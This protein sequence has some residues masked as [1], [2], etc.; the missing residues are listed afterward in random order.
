MIR[1]IA[2]IFFHPKNL[3]EENSGKRKNIVMVIAFLDILLAGTALAIKTGNI[4]MSFPMI[5]LGFFAS[6]ALEICV[7]YIIALVNGI[8]IR[9][10]DAWRIFFPFFTASEFILGI[11]RLISEGLNLQNYA[12][13]EVVFTVIDCLVAV[14]LGYIL[15]LY[16]KT[17]KKAQRVAM[18]SF[19]IY[20]AFTLIKLFT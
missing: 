8:K 9:Y 18:F 6:V 4:L 10:G 2:D 15:F 16:L 11:A 3:F 19:I 14:W 20:S 17:Q 12:I 7:L 13:E 5:T 1:Y